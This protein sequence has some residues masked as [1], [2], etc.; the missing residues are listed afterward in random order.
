L[1]LT[2]VSLVAA[3]EY[4][5][6]IWAVLLG[7]VFFAEVPGINVWIGVGIIA[8]SGIYTTTRKSAAQ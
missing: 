8:L 6:F 5:I 1:R 2:E 4:S 7:A 3:L